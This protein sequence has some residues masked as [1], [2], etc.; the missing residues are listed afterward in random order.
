[1]QH[2]LSH[3]PSG[4]VVQPRIWVDSDTVEA[5]A[6]SRRSGW[7]VEE[8]GRCV[9]IERIH[10]SA[11][12]LLRG[13]GIVGCSRLIERRVEV[14]VV[15]VAVV[16]SS[17]SGPGPLGRQAAGAWLIQPRTDVTVELAL[18]KTLLKDRE[19]D[20]CH[21]DPRT[22]QTPHRLKRGRKLAT[23]RAG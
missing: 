3:P 21:G 13:H 6:H 15:I 20:G 10:C 12:Q 19:V 1:M 16:E 11:I 23:S 8:D 4:Q 2:Y 22:D 17:P 9:R 7:R 18:A 14:A 5:L